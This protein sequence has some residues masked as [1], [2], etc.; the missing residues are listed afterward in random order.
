VQVLAWTFGRLA[1]GGEKLQLSRPG[2]VDDDGT[3]EWIRVDRVAYSD[4]SHPE[5]FANGVDPWPVAADGQGKSLSRI[6]Q[7]TYGNDPANWQPATP[8]PGRANP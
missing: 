2:E 4:G 7:E 6:D 5:D 8:T 3:R 1:N